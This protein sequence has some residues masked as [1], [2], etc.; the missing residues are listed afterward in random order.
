MWNGISTSK[1]NVYVLSSH[2]KLTFCWFPGVHIVKWIS[3]SNLPFNKRIYSSQTLRHCLQALKNTLTWGGLIATPGF[4][5]R[6]I[7]SRVWGKIQEWVLR[8]RS[9]WVVSQQHLWYLK[10][11]TS[12]V[13]VLHWILCAW[14]FL[15]G[16]T[17]E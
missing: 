7:D 17:S 12:C 9:R 8:N 13:A 15:P 3:F 11:Q 16:E 1:W 6:Q 2:S 10:I 4:V 14:D 5:S